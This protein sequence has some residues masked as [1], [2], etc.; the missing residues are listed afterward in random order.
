MTLN[1]KIPEGKLEEKW[2]NYQ[3]QSSLINPANK[4]KLNVIVVGSGLA[5]SGAVSE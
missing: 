5:G 3:V 4:K 1:A 2:R